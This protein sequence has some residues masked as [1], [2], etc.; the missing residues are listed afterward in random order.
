VCGDPPSNE[1]K[2]EARKGKEWNLRCWRSCMR[3]L[4]QQELQEL[5]I[6]LSSF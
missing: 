3:Y 2:E 4:Y 5:T 1:G 6:F